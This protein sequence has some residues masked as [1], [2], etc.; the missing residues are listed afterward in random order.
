MKL[1]IPLLLLFV[2]QLPPNC[3][4]AEAWN[5]PLTL[6]DNNTHISF[7]VDSTWHLIHGK[8]SGVKGNVLAKD[9]GDPKSIH[10]EIRVPVVS[11]DT[12]SPRRDT[13]LREVMG[14]D[15]FSEVVYKLSSVE[16][17]C[18]PNSTEG[19][20]PE[21]PGPENHEEECALSLHGT[22]TIRDKTLPWDIH[23]SLLTDSGGFT[24][25]G[26]GTVR[27]AD[28]GVDD[29]SIFIAKLRPDVLISLIV[30]WKK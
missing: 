14:A 10:G 29:P 21:N 7:E 6:D 28:F 11:F 8:T 5:L 17:N 9:P 20:A 3:A 24:L 25:K 1:A 16:T 12:D 23:A 30:N 15:T 22:L 27:W 19:L 18:S 4:R 13:R 2:A 26:K